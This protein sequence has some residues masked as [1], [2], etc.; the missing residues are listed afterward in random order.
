MAAPAPPHCCGPCAVRAANS[1]AWPPAA[2]LDWAAVPAAAPAACSP[3]GI[4]ARGPSSRE[5][6]TA[7]RQPSHRLRPRPLQR[8]PV[9]ARPPR[10]RTRLGSTPAPPP[11][12]HACSARHA[13]RCAAVPAA[14]AKNR[15]PG[16]PA[17][18]AARRPLRRSAQRRLRLQRP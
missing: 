16:C 5:A 1:S 3:P 9:R 17:R 15:A 10:P 11:A 13:W 14:A 18:R 8:L 2:S 7:P 6:A 12:Q 4:E